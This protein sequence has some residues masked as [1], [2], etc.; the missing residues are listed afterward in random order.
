MKKNPE[1]DIPDAWRESLATHV[2]AWV[3]AN[4]ERNAKGKITTRAA[5][6]RMGMKHPTYVNIT[7]CKGSFGIHMLLQVRAAIKVPLD[8]LLGL[9]PFEEAVAPERVSPAVKAVPVPVDTMNALLGRLEELLHKDPNQ[10][11]PQV[12]PAPPSRPRKRTQ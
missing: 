5:A 6:E 12:P 1:R 9:K 7:T 10:H 3:E 4:V 2:K 8:S 11:I